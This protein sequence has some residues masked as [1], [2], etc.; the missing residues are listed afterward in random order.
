MRYL[1]YRDRADAAA[2]LNT[3]FTAPSG[4]HSVESAAM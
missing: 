1:H 3:A 2:R 4:V